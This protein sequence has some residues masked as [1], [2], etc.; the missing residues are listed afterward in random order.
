MSH[1]AQVVI[2]GRVNVGKSTLF[3][4]LSQR[5][6]SITLD[7]E[8]VTRDYLREE[9]VW[10]DTRF[11]LIDSGG[12][13]LRK[14][15]DSLFEKVRK[16]VLQLVERAD[17]IIFMV[18]GTVG[19]LQ[20]D[21]ELSR[22]IHKLGKPSI[23]IINKMDS[24]RAQE[25]EF[26][27]AQLGF[28]HQVGISAEHGKG[29]PE[30]LDLV[31]DI[32]PKNISHKPA[33]KSAFRVMLLGKPN[34]GKSSLMNALLEEDRALVS[35]IPGTTREAFSEQ[36][37]FYK[38]II[39][40]TDTP[41]IRRQSAVKGDLEPLMV[42]SA[43]N[44]MRSSH[45]I[46][47]L[48]DGSSDTLV[49]QELKL[50]FYVFQ[51][52]SKA[53][54]LLINKDDLVTEQSKASL[55]R[56]MDYYKHLID[57]IPVLHISCKTGKNIGRVLPLVQKLWERTSQTFDPGALQ[58]LC[59]SGLLKKPLYAKQ[60]PLILYK[61]R[62]VHVAP[63]IIELVVNE[64]RWFGPSQLKFFEN[65]IRS[66]YDMQGVPMKFIVKKRKEVK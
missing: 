9:I 45:I 16:Q 41:G 55:E 58:R 25:Q 10:R 46:L 28:A 8:G 35:E 30:L 59:I 3:N 12:I 34:V 32:L 7:F 36:I 13:H 5:V 60:K 27:F 64:S 53:L 51:D 66:E 17:V 14:S 33:K 2:V 54:V 29:I 4:R 39:G 21:H 47:L 24:K 37:T 22:Y 23:L 26:E 38:E 56:S 43:F 62:Q 11:D 18:D 63:I 65:L 19:V 31:M 48:I 6:K 49:D 20:E 57:I 61:V 42:K 15:Q 52:Q 50:A 44:A 40:I 1:V